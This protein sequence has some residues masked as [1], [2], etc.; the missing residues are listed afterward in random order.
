MLYQIH[1]I[2]GTA[3]SQ[4][5]WSQAAFPHKKNDIEEQ[6]NKLILWSNM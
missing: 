1:V 4:L 3:D 6:L 2:T 5:S